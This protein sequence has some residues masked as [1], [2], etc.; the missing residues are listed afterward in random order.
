MLQTLSMIAAMDRNRLIGRGN[1]LP[2]HL[3]ADLAH[4]KQSTLGKP[5]LMGRA[6]HQSIGRPLPGRRNL[7]LSRQ[8]GFQAAGCEVF[9]TAERALE[10]VA[11]AQELVVIG[12]AELYR[13]MLP[14]AQRLYL[15]LIDAEFEGDTWFPDWR[16]D[17]WTPIQEQYRSADAANPWPIRFVTLERR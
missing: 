1:A 8:A 9:E 3:P 12:G 17:P 16:A 6:T 2:W 13:E 10:A 15:S 7:V 14:V 5:I 4:F 11:G